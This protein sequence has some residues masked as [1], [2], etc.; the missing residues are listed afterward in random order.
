MTSKVLCSKVCPAS[1]GTSVPTVRTPDW[2]RPMGF[3]PSLPGYHTP[4]FATYVCM[5][6]TSLPGVALGDQVS[7]TSDPR[8]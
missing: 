6:L 4:R 8:S 3:Y 1:L 7:L 5:F 2:C